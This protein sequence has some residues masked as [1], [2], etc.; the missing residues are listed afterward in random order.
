MVWGHPLTWDMQGAH[1]RQEERRRPLE[2]LERVQRAF[3]GEGRETA[4]H[5]TNRKE[6][7]KTDDGNV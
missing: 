5:N 2:P 7:K 1:R 6:A 4:P 3:M